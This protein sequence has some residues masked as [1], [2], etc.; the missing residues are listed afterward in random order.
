VRFRLARG[1]DAPSS[2]APSRSRVERPLDKFPSRSRAS[3][4]R[5]LHTCSPGRGIQCTDIC[6]RPSQR[7][8]HAT[9]RLGITPRHCSAN[10]PGKAIPTTVQRCAARSATIPWRCA[11]H[12]RTAGAPHSRK[13]TA[14][15]SKE[16]RTTT[17]RPCEDNTVTS[18]RRDRS[19]PS[20]SALCDHPRRPQRHPGHC[21]TI[22]DV[23][24]VCG[25]G[26][27][28]RRLPYPR[29][30][31]RQRHPRVLTRAVAE[32]ET[33]TPP[34]SKPPLDAHRTRHDAPPEAG[35]A[36]TTVYS[37]TLYTMPLIVWHACKLPPPW[38]IKGGA[39]P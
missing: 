20:P 14:E 8:I 7:R 36:R 9:T 6:R 25:D 1:L 37:A 21:I 4:A 30:F 12:S 27:P 5:R 39:V 15:P 16:K 29:T 24:E 13:R 38:P 3:R 17:P 2:E 28:P 34:P 32:Q 10:S 26:T 18:G 11:T 23:M 22:P 19:P 33:S 31:S 35:F